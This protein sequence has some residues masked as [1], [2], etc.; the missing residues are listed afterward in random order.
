MDEQEL[1]GNGDTTRRMRRWVDSVEER[2][3][4]LLEGQGAGGAL[5][6]TYPN[7]GLNEQA[8]DELVA[9]RVTDPESETGRAVAEAVRAV[10]RDLGIPTPTRGPAAPRP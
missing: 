4:L 7:P 3:Q 2:L 8:V 9:A 5:A 1:P 10:L 6:G